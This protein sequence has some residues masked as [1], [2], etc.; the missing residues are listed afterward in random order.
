M[1]SCGLTTGASSNSRTS[2]LLK[3]R[4]ASDSL[5]LLPVNVSACIALI[6]MVPVISSQN[7]KR[8]NNIEVPPA[9]CSWTSSFHWFKQCP[10]SSEM[11]QVRVRLAMADCDLADR[12]ECGS[13]WQQVI[14]NIGTLF[15]YCPLQLSCLLYNISTII[16]FFCSLFDLLHYY[17]E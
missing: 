3:D 8:R 10:C 1:A 13:Q 16:I 15:Y 5:L 17:C 12:Y 6:L 11:T 14:A 4:S 2:H 7:V 9:N